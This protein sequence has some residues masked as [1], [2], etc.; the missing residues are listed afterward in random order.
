[1]EF[2]NIT[3]D[4][5]IRPATDADIPKIWA[6]LKQQRRSGVED[7]LMSG[8]EQYVLKYGT[9]DMLV[10]VDKRSDEHVAYQCGDLLKPGLLEVRTDVRRRGIAKALVEHR[11]AEAA[12]A[13]EDILRIQCVPSSIPF[14][15]S[16]G[17]TI[18]PGNQDE[19]TAF[20]YM[21]RKLP[22]PKNG[23]PV[24][25]SIE[26]FSWE[27]LWNPSIKPTQVDMI[28]GVVVGCN[29]F[30]ARRA[31]FAHAL[32]EPGDMIVRIC[33][34]GVE[35]YREFVGHRPLGVQDCAN[36]WYLDGVKFPPRLPWAWTVDQ[37]NP[38]AIRTEAAD[39]TAY[40]CEPDGDHFDAKASVSGDSGSLS[41]N[42]P[43]NWLTCND[44]NVGSAVGAEALCDAVE[45]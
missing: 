8:F 18:L 19:L 9:R 42:F 31:L 7:S 27:R 25:V 41:S 10:F 17:F 43:S 30:L 44:V 1:M 34:D 22:Q 16:M 29:V 40:D 24:Q 3:L 37:I 14:W 4:E 36:G 5:Y 39:S 32:K 45:G 28:G 26:W 21:E 15:K 6:W 11:M 33:V 12:A 35:W 20:R 2:T 13:G 38:M 23:R